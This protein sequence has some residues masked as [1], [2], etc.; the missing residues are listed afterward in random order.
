MSLLD[1]NLQ[2]WNIR[3]LT[4]LNILWKASIHLDNVMMRRIL[5]MVNLGSL[6]AWYAKKWE[7]CLCMRCEQCLKVWHLTDDCQLNCIISDVV[8]QT[9]EIKNWADCYINFK[10][11]SAHWQKN[12]S[13]I[14]TAGFLEMDLSSL[15]LWEI[16]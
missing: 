6:L 8:R 9:N 5:V 12:N 2:L 14:F 4:Y 11:Y 10:R 16:I 1:Y 3:K 7:L 13:D 15:R